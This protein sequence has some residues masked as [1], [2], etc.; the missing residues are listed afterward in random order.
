MNDFSLRVLIL[1]L[2]VM[3]LTLLMIFEKKASKRRKHSR[4]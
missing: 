3:P 2:F 4:P 1:V